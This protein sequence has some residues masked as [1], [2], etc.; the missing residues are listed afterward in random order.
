MNSPCLVSGLVSGEFLWIFLSRSIRLSNLSLHNPNPNVGVVETLEHHICQ[1]ELSFFCRWNL[2]F[3]KTNQSH[4][5][6][7]NTT[8]THLNLP[9][10]VWRPLFHSNATSNFG[11]LITKMVIFARP[12]YCFH[13]LCWYSMSLHFIPSTKQNITLLKIVK[14]TANQMW[15][16]FFFQT[17]EMKRIQWNKSSEI[18][19]CCHE[20]C[21]PWI[22]RCCDFEVLN[23]LW[24]L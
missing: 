24:C 8:E 1:S 19:R 23:K 7:K 11:V 18:R 10:L 3:L 6:T 13:V 12:F 4:A 20:I 21:D 16:E 14:V 17:K 22:S 9:H 15:R 2:V 5:T